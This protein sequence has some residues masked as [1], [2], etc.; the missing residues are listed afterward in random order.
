MHDAGGSWE[1][2]VSCPTLPA[3][4]VEAM[5]MARNIR[6]LELCRMLM[7]SFLLDFVGY[8]IR[9]IIRS[10]LIPQRFSMND[11]SCLDQFPVI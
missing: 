5:A 6:C 10:L 4:E 2:G 7:F 9:M 11:S 3:P 8:N 1:V